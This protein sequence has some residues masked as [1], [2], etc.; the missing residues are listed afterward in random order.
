MREMQMLA[1][2]KKA[3]RKLAKKYHPDSNE[4]N[5]R[6]AEKFKEINEAYGILG[7]EE[8]RKQYDQLGWAAFDEE[9]A[10]QAERAY[11]NSG[12]F[13][14]GYSGQWHHGFHGGSTGSGRGAH[15]E[16]AGNMDDI[17]KNLFGAG[18]DFGE[19][20]SDFFGRRTDTYNS[21]GFSGED[22]HGEIEVTFDEAAFGGRKV[23]RFQDSSGKLQSLEIQIPAGI[24]SG[25]TI[26]LKEKGMASVHGGKA[27]DL[28]LKITVRKKRDSGE[29]GWTYIPPFPFRFLQQFWAVRYRFRLFMEMCSVRLLREPSQEVKSG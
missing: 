12:A 8:K 11:G 9:E 28:L 29:K 13:G 25:K 3:Y 7:D 14:N 19:N 16:T 17:L 24:S 22:L 6:A 26:R 23:V 1:A 5:S 2:I 4:G 10:W 21:R 15:F 27:G 20:Y 18:A